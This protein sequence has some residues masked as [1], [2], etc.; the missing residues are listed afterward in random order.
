[1]I[2]W[3]K[4][5]N[6]WQQ[7]W[8]EA[9]VFETDPDPDKLKYYLTVAYPY[10][11]SPQHIGHGR[12]YTLTDVH[13]RLMRMKGYNVLLP[14][15]WHY[16][17]TPLFAMVERLKEKDPS[18]IDTFCNLYN[19]PES[20]LPELET[21]V[22]MAR[23]FAK[24]IKTGMQK[25]G[26]SIDWRREFTTIDP[27]YSKFIEWQFTKLRQ[28]GYITQGSHPVGWCPHCGN[29][30]GQHDT[31]GDMEP[32]IEEF[33]LIKFRK[34]ELIFPAATLRPETIY[35]VTN[36]WL[37][38]D[39]L[40]VEAKI[41]GEIWL[42]SEEAV[43]KLEYLGHKVTI[44]SELKGSRF[45]GQKLVN[46]A[47]GKEIIILPAS[48]VNPRNATGVVMSV[49]A[50]APFDY[51]ALE[52]LKKEVKANPDSFKIKPSDIN[53]LDPISIIDVQGNNEGLAVEIVKK[54]KITS[55][56][57]QDLE[58]ATKEVYGTEYHGGRM[59]TNTGTYSGLSVQDAKEAV[60]MD[61][62]AKSDASIMY[63]L[64]EP[65]KCRCGTDVL[66]KIFE[67]QWFINYG[68]PE[69]KRLAKENIEEMEIIP[70]E[71]KQEFV[72]VVDWLKEKACARKA[73][74]GTPLPWAKDW[75]IESLSDSTIYMAYYT[76]INGLN[77]IKPKPEQLTE[78]FWDYVFL[79]KGTSSNIEIETGIPK[80]KLEELHNE[81][82]YFY[83]PEARHSGRDLIP[84]HLTFMIFIHDAI[85]PHE[86]WPQGIVVNGSV[87]ME[88]QKMSKSLNNIIPLSNAIERFGADPLRLS[89]M[90]TAEPLKDAD[91][92]PDLAKSMGDVLEKLYNRAQRI[93]KE[94][95]EDD[96]EFTEVDLWMM[97]RLQNHIQNAN[98]AMID[99]K[100]R[101]TIHS[102]I[103]DL[104]QDLEWY[105]KR[106]SFDKEHAIRRKSIS[107][108]E[109]E[110]LSSQIRMLTPF[111]PHICE[112]IWEEMGFDPFVCFAEW[113]IVKNELVR[114]DAEELELMIKTCIEDVQNIIRVTGIKP[115]LIHYYTADNWKWKMYL[116][117][118]QLQERGQLEIGLLIQE[119]FKDD[120]LK[121]KTKE[122]PGMARSLVDEIKKI[123]E[124]TLGIKKSLGHVNEVKLIQDSI[125]FIR[126]E[127]GCD[128][129][130][131]SESDPW[132]IDPSKRASKA[133]P[134]RP[135][136]YVE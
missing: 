123:P 6:K 90:I 87:L 16:T 107:K 3:K 61:L 112:E 75:I 37:N 77:E 19:I 118:L 97:S 67:N 129:T 35:G 72:N 7:R 132:I 5:E 135:A 82:E 113:P 121:T 60:K 58:K 106:I 46:P 98:E 56:D 39:A 11:N 93:I 79:G 86:K 38:P 68:D 136:I 54:M 55:Q 48:F 80:S 9:R 124:K 71:L 23:Y 2:D 125:N 18:I 128:V 119:S 120:E 85:F 94:K 84:N 41:N 133:K 28:R 69:W 13:A 24:E 1:M 101:K 89:L 110:V 104:E 127:F 114:P 78:V 62:I 36:M 42:I 102:A 96:V 74:M 51:V 15:A 40:Y 44:L 126:A 26:Y 49:P 47:T 116:K 88:G 100:V 17:G 109:W 92:S 63:E 73:G 131:S 76:A 81:F 43:N 29:P 115:N 45:I 50:H 27:Y 105:T 103:Y 34:G 59:K 4:I 99:M 14:M 64:N 25:I 65:V 10:P 117:A 134:Y 108:V 91:F 70:R 12:T 31:V 21:P 130:V 20:K 52:Q 83:P 66:V 122:V 30:V 53:K 57:S 111:T 33:T 95:H 22:S 8:A 32:E